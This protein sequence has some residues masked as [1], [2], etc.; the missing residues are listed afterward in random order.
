MTKDRKFKRPKMRR[1]P[2]LVVRR[3]LRSWPFLVW[4]GVAVATAW[5]YTRS[6]QF[7]GMTGVVES[8]SEEISPLETARLQSVDVAVGQEV[9]AGD[10]VVRMDTALIDARVAIDDARIA[11]AQGEVSGYQQDLLRLANRMDTAILDAQFEL[12]RIRI[13]RERD[14]AELAA[15]DAELKRREGLLAQRL[16]NEQ[17]V[18]E[19]RPPVAALRSTVASYPSL[20]SI[21]DRR[22]AEAKDERRR[23][24]VWLYGADGTDGARN[25]D[26][27]NSMDD[28]AHAVERWRRW[29]E[30]VFAKSQER[31]KRQLDTYILKSASSGIVSRINH[32]PGEVVPAGEPILRIVRKNSDTIVGFLPESDIHEVDIGDSVVVWRSNASSCKTIAIVESISPDIQGLPGRVNPMQPMR[33]RRVIM[34]MQG[35]HGMIPGETVQVSLNRTGWPDTIISFLRRDKGEGDPKKGDARP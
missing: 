25:A 20:V 16:V 22:L 8:F 17:D 19:L 18:A 21:H 3:I 11:E 26:A 32:V 27:G 2:R 9:K 33:G 23:L 1:H 14:E 30:T 31:R 6:V 28:V 35:S 29:Q 4:L 7:G 10:V 34:R 12:E 24:T 15:L 5:I 13:Q